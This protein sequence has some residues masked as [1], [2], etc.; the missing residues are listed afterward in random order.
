MFPSYLLHHKETFGA[1]KSTGAI[2]DHVIEGQVKMVV[3]I[4]SLSQPSFNP[5]PNLN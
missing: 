5:N 4:W 3:D 1:P 2:T